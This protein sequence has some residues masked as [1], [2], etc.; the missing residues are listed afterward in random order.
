[1][2]LALSGDEVRMITR[3]LRSLSS[4]IMV[5]AVLLV[6]NAVSVRGQEPQPAE[7]IK[8]DTN[9]ISVPVIV[10]D[11]ADHYIP[12][13]GVQDFSLFDNNVAQKI[14]VFDNAE[15]PLNIVLMLDTS[16]SASGALGDIRKAAKEFIKEL[17]PQDRAMIVSF[18]GDIDR[19][20]A[21]T[22]DHKVLES[23]IK[24]A[25]G[26]EARGTLLNDAV[27]E[28]LS[29][30]LRPIT[31]RKAI[32]LLSDGQDNGSKATDDELLSYASESDTMIYSIF[33]SPTSQPG[34]GPGRGRWPGGP[35]RFPGGGGGGRGRPFYQYT[36]SPQGYPQRRG[37]GGRRAAQGAAF[38]EQLA[39]VSGGRFYR[40]NEKGLK[41]SFALIADEL[42][43]QYR[44]GFYPEALA[45]DGSLHALKVKVD[46][47]D[48]SVRSRRQYRTKPAAAGN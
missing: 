39:D 47:P 28:V 2:R 4:I 5:A 48:V 31:G 14:A 1:M 18:A 20:C 8:I 25:G 32:I 22:S 34:F 10:S 41:Q 45:Q 27:M 19:L 42:R 40:G 6:L 3:L 15:A 33:Y 21:M 43:Y 37:G 23:A 29:E 36:P 24:H 38:M 30:V 12:G 17:R 16:G 46:R 7:T 44:L 26:G 13:L 11:R 35:G 9:L